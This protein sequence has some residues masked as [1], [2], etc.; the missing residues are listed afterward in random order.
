MDELAL[1]HEKTKG[2]LEQLRNG[3]LYESLPELLF[4]LKENVDLEPAE[5]T[6]RP[7]DSMAAM[8]K[9]NGYQERWAEDIF[10]RSISD[11]DLRQFVEQLKSPSAK[12]RDTGTF[13]FLG[14]AIQ[15]N[16]LTKEQMDWLTA[17]LIGDQ[18]LLNQILEEENDGAYGRSFALAILTILLI[19]D[20]Q[21]AEPFISPE[22]LSAIVEQVALYALLETDTRGF[23]PG[24][25]WV[26]AYT[27]LSNVLSAI[28]D[29]A[30]VPRADKLFLLACLMTNFRQVNTPLTMGEIGRIVGVILSLTKKHALYAEYFL[31]SLKLWRQDL[32]NEPF[33]QTRSRWQKLYIRV[34]FFQQILAYGPEM[35]PEKI[36]AYVQETKNYL[37]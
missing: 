6:P 27:H 2:L 15:N 19:A 4:V 31:M 24:H 32:V 30:D 21:A 18:F 16:H 36:W 11:T 26:H 29:R 9:M 8:E 3:D 1:I 25:G 17:E 35:V 12:I 33:A 13:F 34:D 28:F 22:L 37:S 23:V 10:E 7:S 14:N 20:Q 5:P